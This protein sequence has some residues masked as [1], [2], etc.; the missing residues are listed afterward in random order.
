VLDARRRVLAACRAQGYHIIH[1]RE[2][3]RPDLSDLPHNKLWRSEQIGERWPLLLLPRLWASL[4][5]RSWPAA[6]VPVA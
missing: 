2:G 4:A 3:H 6:S 5:R 1:T